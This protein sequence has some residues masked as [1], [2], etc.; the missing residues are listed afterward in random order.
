MAAPDDLDPPDLFDQDENGVALHFVETSTGK[1]AAGV[2]AGLVV[3][4][5]GVNSSVRNLFYPDEG[6]VFTGINT[7][8]G[9]TRRKTRHRAQCRHECPGHAH[10]Q[11]RG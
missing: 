7:W 2:R 10:R 8:R 1:P 9:V 4:C 3:A 5:D 6:V 11:Q